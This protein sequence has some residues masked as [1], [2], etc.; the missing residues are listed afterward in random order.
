M[1]IDRERWRVLEPL[2][3]HVLELSDDERDAWMIDLRERT[4]ALAAELT[5]LLSGEA[6]ADRAGFLA[7]PLEV[8]L[9]GLSLGA[10][11]LERTL[12]QGG[13][14]SVWLARRTDGRFE[15][16][17]AVKFLNL[18]LLSAHGQAR[19][20]REGSMLARLS[21]P[22]IARLLDAGVAP[23]GQ[24]YLVLEH[25]DGQRIDHY[26]TEHSLPQGARIRL[27]LE[28]VSAV[29]HAHANLIVHRDLKPSNILV[30]RDGVV[31]LLDFGIAK[32]LD[33]DGS[34]DG[35]ALTVEGSRALTP[36]FAAPEQVL[37]G[38]LTTATDVYAL[39]VLLYLLISGRHPTSRMGET[40][41][42]VMRAVLEVEPA[43]L[44][45]G[46]LDTILE[47]SLRKES[48]ARYQTVGA[49]ADDLGRYLRQ[50]PVSARRDSLMYRARKFVLRN[51]GLVAAATLAAIALVGATLFSV[52]QMREAR[53]QRDAVAYARKRAEAQLE[54]QSLLMS[55]AGDAPITMR[56]ILDR[57]RTMLE[58]QYAGD[59]GVLATALI[60]L[61]ARYG[62]LDESKI[63]GALLARAE[64]IAGRDHREL[65]LEIR[66]DMAQVERTQGRYKEARKTLVEVEALLRASPDPRVEAVCLESRAEL[67]IENGSA[68]LAEDAA[69]RAIAIREK[70]GQTRDAFSVDLLGTLAMAVQQGGRPRD[71]IAI[72]RHAGAL[73]DSSARSDLMSH[74]IMMHNMALT[75]ITVGETAD[76]ET[77][78]HDVLERAAR[79]DPKGRIPQQPLIHYAHTALFNLRLDSAEKYFSMLARQAV[80]ERNKYWEGR[81]LFG[82]LQAQVRQGER[83]AARRTATRFRQISDNPDLEH[84]DD[85][86]VDVR[87]V[88]AWLALSNGD[89]AAAHDAVMHV[90]RSSRYV[91][92][93]RRKRLRA[94]LIL[95]AETA[96][97]LERPAVALELAGEARATAMADSLADT[98]SAYVGEA[99][100]LEGRAQLASGDTAAARATLGRAV[101]ALRVGAGAA[102]PRTRQADSLVAAL[103]R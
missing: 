39:G 13:M 84:T 66:C 75:L 42:D 17:A 26:V 101:V 14:G 82:L 58:R 30:T 92:G 91:N 57:G 94:A 36:E 95:G 2:L 98:R 25:V 32:L 59:P 35:T 20:R 100:L 40:S 43:R 22:G 64:S 16:Q 61:S 54:F 65:L 87:M 85:Q 37:A 72:Y 10:Y 99:R 23:S 70:L 18:S 11:T 1:I 80:E 77:M 81:A 79:S 48:A 71:A 96:L 38:T 55:Q 27:F 34:D 88:D 74:A 86:V 90:V 44:G 8:S 102:H 24:P 3:D 28:V 15:G 45:L 62:E 21:H 97:A 51:R 12:G 19:F 53:R 69:A 52:S 63:R 73:M 33:S 83:A 60:E 29:G 93:K 31:K 56:E 50:E 9:E 49:F 103:T 6:V 78:L 41:A 7:I 89:T 67:E 68:R 47:K 5:S 46:D 76:A 4:P